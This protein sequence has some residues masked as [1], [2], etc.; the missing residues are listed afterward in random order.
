MFL[1][2]TA[3]LHIKQNT[4]S[5]FIYSYLDN[6]FNC[7]DILTLGYTVVLVPC[8]K[9]VRSDPTFILLTGLL[10]I[11]RDTFFFIFGQTKK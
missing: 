3:Y 7:V 10:G 4:I 6:Y 1:M 2:G 9:R 5:I 8:R 11:V